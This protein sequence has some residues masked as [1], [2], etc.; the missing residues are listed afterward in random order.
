MTIALLCVSVLLL[1]AAALL[2]VATYGVRQVI[3]TEL[4]ELARE[5]Y[6]IETQQAV[7]D[8]A[9]SAVLSS[10]EEVRGRAEEVADALGER[11]REVNAWLGKLKR[12]LKA[13]VEPEI[14]N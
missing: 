10:N 1:V 8:K 14:F 9:L 11:L 2:L 3:R 12:E 13:E 7:T 6:W 5:L 4:A